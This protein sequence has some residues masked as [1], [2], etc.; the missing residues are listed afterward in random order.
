[1]Q[2]GAIQIWSIEQFHFF[3]YKFS[4]ST[5]WLVAAILSATGQLTL[6]NNSHS[7][8]ELHN[9]NTV[10]ELINCE[11]PFDSAFAVLQG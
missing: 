4:P 5:K 6:N 1:M 7:P 2:F 10:T 8:L 3:I 9:S 11:L